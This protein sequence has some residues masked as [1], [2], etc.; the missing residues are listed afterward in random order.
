MQPEVHERARTLLDRAMV[1]GI[2]ADER[3]WLDTHT[4]QCD[5]CSQYA[6]LSRR[7]I[8]ALDS[9]AFPLDSA[10]ALRVRETV[11]HRA[12]GMAAHGWAASIATLLTLLGSAAMYVSAAWLARQWSLPNPDWQIAFA[13]FWLLPSLML[14]VALL[15]R[16]RRMGDRTL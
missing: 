5:A 13:I 12:A 2:S 15:V 14:D 7:T 11:Q 3:R 6:E 4:A 10:A 1:E 8:A 16:G 9:F